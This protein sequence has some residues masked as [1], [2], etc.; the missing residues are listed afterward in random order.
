MTPSNAKIHVNLPS[1]TEN[2][3]QLTTAVSKNVKNTTF[4]P[5]VRDGHKV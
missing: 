3:I 4:E 2:K 5:R 1:L